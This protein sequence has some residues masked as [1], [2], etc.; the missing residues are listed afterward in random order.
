M[1]I[2]H[3]SA[4][5]LGHNFQGHS[6]CNIQFLETGRFMYY[7][8]NDIFLLANFSIVPII[9]ENNYQNLGVKERKCFNTIVKL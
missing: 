3:D 2:S 5:L 9:H 1:A 8:V 6:I 7:Q 4:V